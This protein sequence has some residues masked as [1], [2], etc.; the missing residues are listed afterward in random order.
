MVPLDVH[1]VALQ[2]G[3]LWAGEETWLMFMSGDSTFTTVGVCVFC[4]V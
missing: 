3:S 2:K 1:L 4:Y